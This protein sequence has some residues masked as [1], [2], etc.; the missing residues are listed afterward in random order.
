MKRRTANRVL[1]TEEGEVYDIVVGDFL[2][3]G[4]GED[5]FIDL[6]PELTEK[7]LK[8]FR[9]PQY[10]MRNNGNLVMVSGTKI[11]IIG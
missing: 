5:D 10:F 11:E 6:S 1:R 2:L 8:Y 7:Y 9:E 3:V 4:L